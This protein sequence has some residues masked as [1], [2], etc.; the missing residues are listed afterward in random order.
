MSVLN[1]ETCINF[2]SGSYPYDTE[3]TAV[4]LTPS[5]SVQDV[6]RSRFT[7]WLPADEDQRNE[8][9]KQVKQYAAEYDE[10]IYAG[11]G[12]IH[13]IVTNSDILQLLDRYYQTKK[14]TPKA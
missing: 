2:K 6:L 11:K 1:I 3:I 13:I 4:D 10:N 14:I 7:Q 9:I 8:T 12:E 5:I